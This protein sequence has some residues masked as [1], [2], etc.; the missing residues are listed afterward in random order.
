MMCPVDNLARFTVTEDGVSRIRVGLFEVAV[1]GPH[2][3][4]GFTGAGDGAP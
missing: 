1:I 4:Y 2:Q 3:R